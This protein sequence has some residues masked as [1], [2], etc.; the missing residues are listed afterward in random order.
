MSLTIYG[1]DYN[2]NNTNT[3]DLCKKNLTDFPTEICKFKNVKTLYLNE[4]KLYNLPSEI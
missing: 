2:I 4:N 1:L 3:L